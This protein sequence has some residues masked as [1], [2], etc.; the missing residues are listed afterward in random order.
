M[1]DLQRSMLGLTGLLGGAFFANRRIIDSWRENPDPLDGRIPTFPAGTQRWVIT[2]DG[3]HINTVTVEP[4]QT[5][6]GVIVLLHG[7]TSQMADF[8]PIAERLVRDGYTVIGVDQRGH[9]NSV[10]G[11]DGFSA[12]RQG[13]DMADVLRQLDIRQAIL[14]GHSMGG[15]ATMQLVIN[16]PN[17]T[18]ERLRGIALIATSADMS[19]ARSQ[20]GLWIGS[21]KF[22]DLFLKLGKR[23][24]IFAG[25]AAFGD[26]PSLF[27]VDAAIA[28][29][30][31]CPGETR[32]GATAGLL[33]HNVVGLL[34][35]ITIPTLVVTGTKDRLVPRSESD[36]L[37]DR[38]PNAQLITYQG[39]GHMMIWEHNA[40]LSL[41]LGEFAEGLT[42][43]IDIS[44]S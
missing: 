34:H 15:M 44:Q 42:S 27:M 18:S 25:L 38:I 1:P 40:D 17:L 20:S 21:Q 31:S 6:R 19:R 12:Q 32:R 5:P 43:P 28:S 29:S 9:G 36:I 7:L 10:V 3:A 39:A 35:E 4:D 8:G 26:E 37:V 41:Q 13:T 33:A 14:A 2:D 30:A 16:N 23:S 22:T 11:S 24:R